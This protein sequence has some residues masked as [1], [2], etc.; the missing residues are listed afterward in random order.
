MEKANFKKDSAVLFST[1]VFVILVAI[2][3]VYSYSTITSVDAN[4]ESIFNEEVTDIEKDLAEHLV[5]YSNILSSIK[6]LFVASQDVER[7][8]FNS[9]IDG[10]SLSATNNPV[11]AFSYI[12]R[13][14]KNDLDKFTEEVRTAGYSEFDS[15]VNLLFPNLKKEEYY[16]VKYSAPANSFNNRTIGSDF[17]STNSGILETALKTNLP[18]AT[19]IYI[20]PY[21]N[22]NDIMVI[23]PIYENNSPIE[24]FEE[25]KKNI[26]GLVSLT[27]ETRYLL[28]DIFIPSS[29]NRLTSTNVFEGSETK[30][31][32]LIYSNSAYPSKNISDYAFIKTIKVGG[33]YWTI[34]INETEKFRETVSDTSEQI[35]II[36]G[37]IIISLS[38]ALAS[39]FILS[40]RS[41]AL[42]IAEIMT[43]DLGESEQRL[44]RLN[45]A[46]LTISEA[47]QTIVK[48]RDEQ[49]LLQSVCDILVKNAGYCL[50]WVGYAENDEGKS[51]RV[52]AWS[53]HSDGYVEK[54]NISWSEKSP[55]GQGP[56]GRAIREKRIVITPDFSKDPNF[57]PWR[58]EA[59]NRGYKGSIVIPLESDSKFFGA[60]SIY[61]S[62]ANIFSDAEIKMLQELADDLAFSISG[63][64]TSL[65]KEKIEIKLRENIQL[66]S[67]YMKYSPIYTFI[68]EVT[69]TE[70]RVIM[71]SE[72]YKDM[73][74]IK[75]VDMIGKTMEELFPVEFAAKITAD[76]W[77]VASSGKV[78]RTEEELNGRSYTTIKFPILTGGKNLLAGYTIDITERKASEQALRESEAKFRALY[79]S[80]TEMVA[81]HEIIYN[82]AGKPADYRI[83]DIN[84]AFSRITG[85]PH[86][87]AVNAL[88][89]KLYGTGEAPYLDI[90]AEVASTGQ[91]KEFEAYFPPMKKYFHISSTSPTRGIF[92]T[93]SLDITERWVTEKELNNKMEELSRFQTAVNNASDHIIITDSDAKIIYANRGVEQLTGYSLEEVIGKTPAVWGKQ[94]PKAFYEK[95]WNTLKVDKKPFVGEI[96]NK[97]KNGQLY[98]A[99]SSIS[100]IINDKGEIVYFVG[101]ERDITKAKEIEKAKNE[102]VSLASH[103]LRTPLTAINWYS[104][105]L[106]GGEAGGLNEKQKEYVEELG[107]SSRRMTELVGSLLNVSRV[108]LGTFTIDPKP[109]DIAKI[110]KDAIKDIAPKISKKKLKIVEE[111]EK[112]PKI[113]IDP[114]LLEIILQNLISNAVKYTPELGTIKV[115]IG[116]TENEIIIKVEDNGYGIPLY[117]QE[118]VF[119]KFFR[120]DNIIP[121]E[122][123]GN[124]LGLY[125]VKQILNSSGGSISFTSK[126]GVGSTFEVK[127]PLSGMSRREGPRILEKAHSG[128]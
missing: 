127:L 5:F 113:N 105:M 82:E 43:K 16:L 23:L 17:L 37:G 22:K 4:A 18:T 86:E 76:D 68:K 118:K 48:A 12:E 33:K 49:K 30:P 50:A 109:T 117:Q 8:E 84:P 124:G 102:F 47:N 85:I 83:I 51:V 125:M 13:V 34:K 91:P 20:N 92:A 121:V 61:S 93:T 38:F 52:A 107:S 25:R 71:S 120:A 58:K 63:I 40:S 108:D 26:K 126:E 66:L 65:E 41:R 95:M 57:G 56:T 98:D 64:R 73:I 128:I 15:S 75:G 27:F 7:D 45:R 39:Y 67:M 1:L 2:T 3:G 29:P 35:Y 55:R 112:L 101:V 123:D 114:N 24:T 99:E 42:K 115:V 100:P 110:S 69:P 74:G 28:N 36:I 72:N 62:E 53:G 88:A 54:L 96:K 44:Q 14:K 19:E 87:K 77:K 79:G 70:S 89:S 9:F 90:Y 31:E 106:L 21:T 111:Y 59:E 119:E 10:L 116:K 97:R 78:L 104:E 81:L 94:M 46:L 6:G 80:M 60:I 11:A 103:Q 32:S 122:T